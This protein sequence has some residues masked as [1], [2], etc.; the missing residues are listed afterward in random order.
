M[1]FSLLAA[2]LLALPCSAQN[3]ASQ[4]EIPSVEVVATTPLPGV[5]T[6]LSQVPA[7]VQTFTERTLAGRQTLHVADHLQRQ[8]ASVNINEGQS[9]PY[10][11]DLNFRGFTASPLL[12]TPQGLSVFQ[13]GVRI[14]EGFGDIV[15]WDLLPRTAIAGISLLPGSNA[16]FGLNTL[17]GALS[18]TTKSGFQYP[19][20]ML[21]ASA[22]AHGRRTAE[23]EWGGHDEDKDFFL[24]VDSIRDGGWREHQASQIGRLFAKFGHQDEKNDIDLSVSAADNTLDGAQTLPLSMLGNPRQTYTWPDSTRNQLLFLNLKGSRALDE[25][26]LVVGNFYYRR[27]DSHSLS[28]NLNDACNP[29]PCAFNTFNNLVRVRDTRMGASLQLTLQGKIKGLRNQLTTG[30][31]SDSG[32]ARFDGQQQNALLNADRSTAGVSDFV[33]TAGVRALHDYANL[34]LSDT[35]S[36]TEALHLTGSASY[37]FARIDIADQTGTTPALNATHRF[38]RIN[39]ALGLAYS[40]SA[41]QTWFA[42]VSQGM[43]APTSMELSCADPAAPCQLPNIFLADPPLKPVISRTLEIGTRQKFAGD[44]RMSLALFRTGLQDDIQFISSGGAALN[45][46]YFQNIGQTRRQGVEFGLD[47]RSSELGLGL[48]YSLTDATYRSAFK[49]HSPNNSSRDEAGDIRVSPGNRIP[50]IPRQSLK[51]SA[52]YEIGGNTRLGADLVAYSGQYA[53]GNE[54]NGN[55]TLPGYA[56]L[57]LDV[58]YRI[59]PGWRVFASVANLFDRRYASFGVL[60]ANFFSAPGHGF[61]PANVRPEQFRSPG[62]PRSFWIGIEYAFGDTRRP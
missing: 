60:G 50:G 22:G 26:R 31:A 44:L 21:R 7:N 38:A 25:E 40:P 53:R 30:L 58:A 59:E 29:G 28:S 33:Q 18:I 9:N 24:A 45:A 36:F 19:G 20:T 56:V 43:R 35:L 42:G 62:A 37:N 6:P 61:D 17:G 39:P 2:S 3:V 13:D 55:G 46:G 34:Y 8:A 16:V 41:M 1:R 48:R 11:P 54:N 52:D 14:N 51:L 4:L 27:L 23:L 5:G 10:Q 15:N 47:Q 57:N 32:E 49:A 12:G